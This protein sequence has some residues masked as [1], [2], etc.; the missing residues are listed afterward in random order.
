MEGTQHAGK[1]P[2]P[3]PTKETPQNNGKADATAEA[4]V[5]VPL[6]ESDNQR[7]RGIDEFYKKLTVDLSRLPPAASRYVRRHGFL[8][9]EAAA[10]WQVGY[11]AMDTKGDRTGST[12]RG[13]FV[14]AIH[15]R[16]GQRVAYAGRDAD[17]ETKHNAWVAGR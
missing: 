6:A 12:M 14:V 11:L 7:V 5:N 16:D 10:R 1:A 4:K 9:E 13:K 15:N 8:T 17:W 2:V 3:S